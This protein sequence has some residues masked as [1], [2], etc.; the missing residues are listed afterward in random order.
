MRNSCYE[1]HHYLPL[2]LEKAE[3]NYPSE[4]VS[5]FF[6]TYKLPECRL[7]LWQ[8]LKWYGR[9]KDE[10]ILFSAGVHFLF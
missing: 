3:E 2:W 6:D 5:E 9:E 8:M 4:V 1:P 7:Y 10:E